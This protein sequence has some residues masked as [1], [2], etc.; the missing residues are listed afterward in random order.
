MPCP[1][2]VPAAMLRWAA[3]KDSEQEDGSRYSR[4]LSWLNEHEPQ[5]HVS[6]FLDMLSYIGLLVLNFIII[7]GIRNES[8]DI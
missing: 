5:V 6:F 4:R 8:F 1:Y 3:L 2:C 7:H